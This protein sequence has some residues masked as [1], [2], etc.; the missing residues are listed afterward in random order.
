[1]FLTVPLLVVATLGAAPPQD[2]AAAATPVKTEKAAPVCD[3]KTLEHLKKEKKALSRALDAANEEIKLLQ[4]DAEA[5][6]DR[7]GYFD[8]LVDFKLVEDIG[9]ITYQ[10][11]IE[12]Q[13]DTVVAYSGSAWVLAVD[14]SK[15]AYATLEQVGAEL[16]VVL[17]AAHVDVIVPQLYKAKSA[18]Y[19]LYKEHVEEHLQVVIEIVEQYQVVDRITTAYSVGVT[20]VEE[21]YGFA[22]KEA[23]PQLLEFTSQ[24]LSLHTSNF[25]SVSGFLY[26]PFAITLF[27]EKIVF[28]DGL[29][30]LG[31]VVLFGLVVGYFGVYQFLIKFL[32]IKVILKFLVHRVI[33]TWLLR[34]VLVSLIIGLLWRIVSL[35]F[36]TIVFALKLMCFCGCCGYCFRRS[37]P[38]KGSFKSAPIN[39]VKPPSAPIPPATPAKNSHKSKKK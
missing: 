25:S 30:D 39:A 6:Q 1:M 19:D 18:I 15:V 14:S 8:K 2:K 35:A 29:Y 9:R 12:A 5:K 10:N 24:K 26:E 7:G 33:I 20:F 3:V 23:L 36:G 21:I 11:L 4:E 17:S 37:K 32:V 31:R 28:T 13:Y 16:W 34:N 38:S 27:R 22:T